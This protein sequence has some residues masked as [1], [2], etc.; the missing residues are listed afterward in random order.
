MNKTEMSIGIAQKM[1]NCRKV[2]KVLLGAKYEER[3]KFYMQHI[4]KIIQEN[5]GNE[6]EAVLSITKDP[7]IRDNE[8]DVMLL[9]AAAIEINEE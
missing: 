6:I 4:K 2:A 7:I 5:G 8:Q 9:M 1:Y 3:I